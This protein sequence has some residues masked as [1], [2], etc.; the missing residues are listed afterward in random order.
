MHVR[1]SWEPM[2]DSEKGGDMIQA[3]EK[4]SLLCFSRS[5]P[6]SHQHPLPQLAEKRELM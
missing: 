6:L 1:G 5:S 2:Q 4:H 3:G